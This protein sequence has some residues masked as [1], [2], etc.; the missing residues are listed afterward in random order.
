MAGACVGNLASG[1]DDDGC[2]VNFEIE[3]RKE[4]L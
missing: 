4:I 1:H 2:R 3:G